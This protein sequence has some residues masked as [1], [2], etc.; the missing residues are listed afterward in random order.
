MIRIRAS[1]VAHAQSEKRSSHYRQLNELR[2]TEP[3]GAQHR[4]S[5]LGENKIKYH[6]LHGRLL[7][8]DLARTLHAFTSRAHSST[9]K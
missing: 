8:R 7:D 2:T 3:N 5:A 1:A 6:R 4:A 9:P